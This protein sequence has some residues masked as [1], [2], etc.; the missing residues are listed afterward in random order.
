MEGTANNTS[1]PGMMIDMAAHYL[2]HQRI[3]S[4]FKQDGG[5]QD[6]QKPTHKHENGT[7]NEKQNVRCNFDRGSFSIEPVFNGSWIGFLL[8]V[9]LPDSF[10]LLFCF[11][12][13]DF[14]HAIPVLCVDGFR[15]RILG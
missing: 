6:H 11:R 12:N 13:G 2:A 8:N 4:G 9:D 14:Q 3:T 1:L 5:R 15:L 10:W 7:N